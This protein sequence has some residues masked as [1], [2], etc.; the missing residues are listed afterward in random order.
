M[1]GGGARNSLPSG[2]V[3][4]SKLFNKLSSFLKKDL[5]LALSSHG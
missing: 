3:G 1:I 2:E 5:L 4:E